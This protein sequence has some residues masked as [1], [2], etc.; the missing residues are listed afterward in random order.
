MEPNSTFRFYGYN[1]SRWRD[2]HNELSTIRL[3]RMSYA[4]QSSAG[5]S[6]APSTSSLSFTGASRIDAATF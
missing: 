4:G 1:S 3:R 6:L 5:T 2:C